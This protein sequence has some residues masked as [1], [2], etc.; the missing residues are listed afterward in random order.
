MKIKYKDLEFREPR[1]HPLQYVST[2]LKKFYDSAD[3]AEAYLKLM[4]DTISKQQELLYAQKEWSVLIV[5]QGLDT[6]GKD[7][8]IKH[9]MTGINPNGCEVTNFKQPT[10]LELDHDFL[11]RIHQELPKRGHIGV[12]NRSYYEDIV[13]P[14]VHPETL[15]A[16]SIP[17][18]H[19]KV[20]EL[21]ESRCRDVVN[22]EDYLARQGVLI[23]KFFLHISKKEQKERLL[24]RLDNP[25]K[26]WKF[27]EADVE[28]RKYWDSYQKAYDYCIGQTSHEAAPWYILPSNDKLTARLL[29]SRIILDHLE[30][31]KLGF[32]EV[33][34]EKRKSLAACRKALAKS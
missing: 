25:E 14:F 24:A 6:A 9:V 18:R 32:P 4:Q 33:T 27:S 19:R 5:L 11:W 30:A 21:L 12:F 26:N 16:C 13:V 29:A 7:G 1:K 28:E 34:T 3:E 2:S 23:I 22:F 8:L 10:V 17:K 31:L 15:E 20:K